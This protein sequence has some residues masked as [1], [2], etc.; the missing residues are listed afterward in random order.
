[1]YCNKC[2]GILCKNE[3]QKEKYYDTLIGKKNCE[4]E[5]MSL[6]GLGMSER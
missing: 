4:R 3:V 2:L 1:M 5:C 6:E